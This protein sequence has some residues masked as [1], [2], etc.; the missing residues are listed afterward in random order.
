MP[1][2]RNSIEAKFGGGE[3]RVESRRGREG[4]KTCVGWKEKVDKSRQQGILIEVKQ[5][6]F[7]NFFL[8][9]SVD[10]LWSETFN[11]FYIVVSNF[12]LITNDCLLVSLYI[13]TK[14]HM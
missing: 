7:G 12:F 5:I 9:T 3:K 13:V 14:Y 8:F 11:S 6:S 1:Q 2:G 10:M 4:R